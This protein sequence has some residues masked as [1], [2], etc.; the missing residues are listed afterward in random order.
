MKF[1]LAAFLR[2]TLPL[3][4]D[5]LSAYDNDRYQAV[6]LPDHMVSFWPDAIWT[7]EFTD[8]ALTSPSPH[9]YVDS[10][11]V[12]GAAAV[13]T[14]HV[15]IATKV[16]DTVRRHPAMLAQSALTVDHLSKGRFILGLGSGELENTVPYG[17]EFS[18]PV[19]R[20]EEALKVI[21]LLWDTDGPVDFHGEFFQL[22]HARLDTEPYNGKFPRI[23]I[24]SQGPR[25]L[26]LTG[27]YA[28]GWYPA[29]V[30]TP[31]AYADKLKMIRDAAERHNRDPFAIV[32]THSAP[33]LIGDEDEVA[34]MLRAPLVK[35]YV[36][37]LPAYLLNMHGYDHPMGNDWKGIHDLNPAA[38][39]R[40]VLIDL[41]QRVDVN[42]LRAVV[43]NG[44]PKQVAVYYK[45]FVDAGA[46]VQ[47]IVDYGSMAGAKFAAKSAAKVRE[48]EEELLRMVRAVQ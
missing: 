24:G 28:D 12:A 9:R 46:R 7:P 35:S 37:Q 30:Y 15:P 1:Q 8:L 38:L 45:T 16:V 2:T 4:L 34:E 43:P 6:W 19:G 25:M 18:K 41:F 42:A 47:K 31:E 40:E 44:T 5:A 29:G 17:F 21:R 11:V 48:A 14:K 23:Y 39:T 22:E 10:F 20:F 13:L 36:L 32:P 3:G 26:E 27:K 33:A